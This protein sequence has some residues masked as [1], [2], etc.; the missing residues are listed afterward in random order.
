MLRWERSRACSVLR[1]LYGSL[2]RC[3]LRRACN[4]APAGAC[5]PRLAELAVLQRKGGGA[6][7]YT[8]VYRRGRF[9]Y[10]VYVSFSGTTDKT[11]RSR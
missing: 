9:R 3:R 6:A 11:S 5:K 8:V 2:G 10:E 1:S 7:G 4:G